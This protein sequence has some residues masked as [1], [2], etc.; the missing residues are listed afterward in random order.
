M[1][2]GDFIEATGRLES[3]YGK[4]YT[5]EQR[6]IMFEEL[7]N[8]NIDRYKQI[9]ARYI[10]TNKFLPKVADILEINSELTINIIKE[11]AEEIEKCNKCDSRGFILYKKED[12]E[13]NYNYTYV[14]RCTC[15]NA[16]KYLAFPLVTQ[17]GL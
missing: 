17:I 13:N 5:T 9:I 1:I 7:K 4:E 2:S 10:R 14:C 12:K 15:K 3:Y 11:K 6:Q 16:N 8:I